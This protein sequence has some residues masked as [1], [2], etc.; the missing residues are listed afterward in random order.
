MYSGFQCVYIVYILGGMDSFSSKLS[1][2]FSSTATDECC[3][4]RCLLHSVM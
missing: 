3:S 2:S 1:S 4:L